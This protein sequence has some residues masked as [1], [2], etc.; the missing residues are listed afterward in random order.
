MCKNYGLNVLSA[1]RVVSGFLGE[2]EQLKGFGCRSVLWEW[3]CRHLYPDAHCGPQCR[4]SP[5]RAVGSFHSNWSEIFWRS[6][7]VQAVVWSA[8]ESDG[9]GLGSGCLPEPLGIRRSASFSINPRGFRPFR[10]AWCT[11][12]KKYSL[13]V[14]KYDIQE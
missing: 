5:T 9:E 1:V 12:R 3:K 8:G 11:L 7:T 13:L 10:F 14:S 4:G 2:G 6:G